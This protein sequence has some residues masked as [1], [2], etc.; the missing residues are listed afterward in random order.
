MCRSI[1]LLSKIPHQMWRDH[2]LSQE[3][4]TTERA[5]GVGIGG[6]RERGEVGQRGLVNIGGRSS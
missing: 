3:N 6:N 4:K 5:V 1:I 2:P